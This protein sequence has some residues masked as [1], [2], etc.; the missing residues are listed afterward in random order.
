MKNFLPENYSI[1]EGQSNYYKFTEG[2]NRFRVLSS[3]IVGWELWVG[4]KPIRRKEKTEFLSEQLD[5]ADINKFTNKKKIPQAFWA[6]TAYNYQTRKIEI[7]EVIQVTIMRGMR[8][9]LKDEDYG[10]DPKKYDFIVVRDESGE[11]T[12]YRVKA[13]PP[14]E[15]DAGIVRLVKDT[16]I[17][18]Q[19]LFEGKDPFKQEQSKVYPND[20]PDNLEEK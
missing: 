20:I 16:N 10:E 12:E 3:A 9:Y 19:A 6:F 17:N 1:P 15:L 11:K 18:L 2:E 5:K 7:L 14:K 8:D 13:K 4:G